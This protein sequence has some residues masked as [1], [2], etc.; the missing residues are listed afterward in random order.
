MAQAVI[1]SVVGTEISKLTVASDATNI[2]T[3]KAWFIVAASVTRD[4]AIA[5][6]KNMLYRIEGI[7][8]AWPMA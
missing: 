1:K 8:T 4:D 7:A 3:D 6:L 2:G 5:M